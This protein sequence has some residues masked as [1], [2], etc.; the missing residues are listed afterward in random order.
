MNSIRTS[1][2]AHQLLSRQAVHYDV[3]TK[4]RL[5]FR[6]RSRALDKYRGRTD[7]FGS[8]TKIPKLGIN[9]S[10]RYRTPVGVYAYPV[11]Y[12][13][14]KV[15][16]DIFNVPFPSEG[17][18]PYVHIFSVSGLDRTLN[19]NMNDTVKINEF[20]AEAPDD[21]ES[22]EYNDVKDLVLKINNYVNST[23]AEIPGEYW[24]ATP[25]WK[26]WFDNLKKITGFENDPGSDISHIIMY[27]GGIHYSHTYQILDGKKFP[28]KR[29]LKEIQDQMVH[30]ERPKTVMFPYEDRII[31]LPE[32]QDMGMKAYVNFKTTEVLAEGERVV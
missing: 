15:K 32:V 21:F 31:K 27:T 24:D 28:L 13:L 12:I 23:I 17:R 18:V 14:D 1:R 26:G 20:W 9:P 2:L 30:L 4:E 25:Q 11:D 7:V 10:T 3:A 8:F 29:V 22:E 19:F 5:I 16:G 6:N